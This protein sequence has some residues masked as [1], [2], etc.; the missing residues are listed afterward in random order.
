MKKRV[1][2]IVIVIACI[3]LSGAAFVY[4]KSEKSAIEKWGNVLF[5]DFGE[6]KV[7]RGKK[8]KLAMDGKYSENAENIEGIAEAGKDV[9][10]TDDEI[11]KVEEFYKINGDS[12]KTANE[13]AIDY[14]EEQNALYAEAI[15]K[16]YDVTDE[17]LDKYIEELKHTASIVENK[18]VIDEIIKS[19]DSEEDYWEYE[20]ELY[21][22]L[23][24]I[25][26]YVKDLENNYIEKNINKKTEQ[27]IR[28]GWD[29]KLDEIKDKAVK[30]QNFK[31]VNDATDIND[32][33]L[34]E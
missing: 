25:Q 22:K 33:F 34:E 14:V 18:E 11:E 6:K 19:F 13:K 27:E 12:E 28:N 15:K 30:N 20:R 16:G 3:T 10:V 26:K 29:R 1:I 5:N 9:L 8:Y 4:A 23:L 32:K 31:K 7:N 17:E 21:K 2:S 24:P